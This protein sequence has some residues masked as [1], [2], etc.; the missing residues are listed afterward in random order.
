MVV[1]VE[2]VLNPYI[3]PNT[4][5]ANY[6]SADVVKVTNKIYIKFFSYIY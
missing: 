4:E 1:V 5:K 3:R 2:G 6:F